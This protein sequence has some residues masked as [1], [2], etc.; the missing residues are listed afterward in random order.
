MTD[1]DETFRAD[2][3]DETI[4]IED[5][6]PMAPTPLTVPNNIDD[7]VAQHMLNLF[8]RYRATDIPGV[9][10]LCI[11]A[12]ASSGARELEVITEVALGEWN[13]RAS[14]KSASLCI[15]FEKS[16]ERY[17]EQC[18]YEVKALPAS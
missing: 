9:I 15:S 13:K 14:F 11:K 16:V 1:I 12:T 4:T 18:C 2:M 7:L 17:R 3:H 6:F 10:E 5:T 8:N